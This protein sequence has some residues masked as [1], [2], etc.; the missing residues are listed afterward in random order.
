MNKVTIK[1]E[2]EAAQWTLGGPL[3]DGTFEC[4]PEVEWSAARD[5]IY[6][7]YG[8]LRPRH[9]LGARREAVPAEPG[10]A[11]GALE[12]LI[13]FTPKEGEPYARKMYPF[14]FWS[15]KSLASATRD[16]R[17]VFLDQTDQEMVRLWHDYCSAEEW[18]NPVPRMIEFRE[19]SGQYGRGYRPHYMS[20]GD[21]LLQEAGSI[22]VVSDEEFQKMRAA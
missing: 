11:C 14:A 3:P 6:F 9:W 15:V 16:W 1:R 22:K 18:P 7:T 5:L 12:G 8:N 19:M 13:V 17:P 10:K 2:I 20:S 4:V 21:W